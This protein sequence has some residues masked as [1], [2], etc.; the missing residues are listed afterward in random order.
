[1]YMQY[2]ILFLYGEDEYRV[3]IECVS[4]GSTKST[5]SSYVTIQ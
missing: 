5:K 1:M 2:L 3:D 4:V